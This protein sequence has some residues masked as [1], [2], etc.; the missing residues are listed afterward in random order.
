VLSGLDL[1]GSRLVWRDG[2]SIEYLD[3]AGGDVVLLG[4]GPGMGL[5]WQPALSDRYAVWFEAERRRGVA[6]RLIAYDTK[7]GRR[8][9]LGEV[10]SVRSAPALSG[11]L[12]VWCSALRPG[13]SRILGASVVAPGPLIPIADGEGAP[14]VSGGLVVWAR[15]RSGPFVAA[16]V[17]GGAPWPVA[18]SPTSGALTGMALSGRTL[19]WGQTAGEGGLGFVAAVDVDGG[20]RQTV[21]SGVAGLA[22]P[23][24]DGTT[25]VWAD[26]AAAGARVMARRP[27]AGD[28]FVVA[29]VNGVVPDV[30]VSGDLAA[31]IEQTRGVWSIIVQKLPR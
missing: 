29:A 2:A 28:A 8:R 26:N 6:A 20:G 24:Y 23:S 7:I 11:D 3:L 27:G 14:V 9:T 16:E 22:G 13:Q 18:A 21:A 15:S 4:P 17:A 19:V 1:D 10:G 31:W 12:A 25:V 30:A 5:T